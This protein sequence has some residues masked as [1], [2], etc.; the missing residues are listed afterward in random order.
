MKRPTTFDKRIMGTIYNGKNKR[1]TDG[2]FRAIKKAITKSSK[3]KAPLFKPGDGHLAHV[4]PWAAIDK[5]VDHY[6]GKTKDLKDLVRAIFEVDTNAVAPKAFQQ[7]SATT[8]T[9]FK[10]D[11]KSFV[12]HSAY[13]GSSLVQE[14]TDMETEALNFCQASSSSTAKEKCKKLLFNAPAN[15]RFG[16]GKKNSEISDRLDFMGSKKSFSIPNTGLRGV[17]TTK[18]AKL[19]EIYEKCYQEVEQWCGSE[20]SKTEHYCEL[21][22]KSWGIRSSSSNYEYVYE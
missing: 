12:Q 9:E 10:A 19:R 6:W 21:H 11:S 3:S 2:R 14:N 17:E 13:L 16:D 18:E 20:K 1:K 7:Q 15:L 8:P 5:C 4:F 22:N